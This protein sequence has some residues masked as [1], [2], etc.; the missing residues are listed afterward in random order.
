MSPNDLPAALMLLEYCTDASHTHVAQPL[1]CVTYSCYPTTPLR[2]ILML[3]NHSPA[4]HASATQRL[5]AQ[6][7]RA[8]QARR[9]IEADARLEYGSD[10][11]HCNPPTHVVL[12]RVRT[13]L[14]MDEFRVS[15]LGF[16]FRVQ[17][18]EFRVQGLEFMAWG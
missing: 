17:G 10:R 5:T 3:L 12:T 16:G 13:C 2:H 11:V 7:L 18:L 9:C 14:I 15:G 6:S 8:R 4:L 1:P